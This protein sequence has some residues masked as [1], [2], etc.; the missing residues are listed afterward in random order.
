[1]NINTDKIKQ[2]FGIFPYKISMFK[3]NFCHFSVKKSELECSKLS[4]LSVSH[5]TSAAECLLWLLLCGT[6]Y[7]GAKLLLVSPLALFLFDAFLLG[8]LLSL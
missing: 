8:I 4:F 6:E 2:F 7:T 1:M 3:D 5:C